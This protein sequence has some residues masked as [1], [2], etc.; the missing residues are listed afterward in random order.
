MKPA[1]FSGDAK[2]GFIAVI[3]RAFQK[4]L[5]NALFRSISHFFRKFPD[6]GGNCPRTDGKPQRRRQEV[7]GSLNA[8]HSFRVQRRGQR[9]HARSILHTGSDSFRKLPG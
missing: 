4:L 5:K 2:A 7:T 9:F 6:H 8:H 3:D 1:E